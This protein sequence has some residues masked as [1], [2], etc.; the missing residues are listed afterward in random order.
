MAAV[1]RPATLADLP[2]IVAMRDTL[3]THELVGSPH[4]PIQRLTLEQFAAF[5]SATFSDPH[6]CWRIVEVDGQH[7]GFGLIYM[8]AKTRLPG[9]FIHWAYVDE[10]QRRSGLGRLLFDHLAV[11]AREQG[12]TRI[13]L[14]YIDNNHIAENFWTK[15]G[16]QSYAHKCVHYL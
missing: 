12:A 7:V 13:E 11:W 16:F 10:A 3:N 1:I 8:L 9:A 4:A 6:H 2:A 14:Q 15:L 5:W